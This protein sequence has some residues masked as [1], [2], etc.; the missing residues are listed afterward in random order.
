MICVFQSFSVVFVDV[1]SSSSIQGGVCLAP[2]S[3]SSSSKSLSLEINVCYG[4]FHDNP[5]L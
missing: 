5:I 4:S 1:Q 2:A 3:S